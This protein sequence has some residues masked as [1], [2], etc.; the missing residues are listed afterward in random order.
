MGQADKEPFGAHEHIGL[1]HYFL[2]VAGCWDFP[3]LVFYGKGG[4]PVTVILGKETSREYQGCC[5]EIRNCSF[6]RDAFKMQCKRSLRDPAK[7][8]E[9]PVAGKHLVFLFYKSLTAN[10]CS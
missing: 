9:R 2:S 1:V 6:F 8:E 5:T 3:F 7:I 10:L 4:S